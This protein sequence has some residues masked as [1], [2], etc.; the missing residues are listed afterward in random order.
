MEPYEKYM[1]NDFKPG[2]PKSSSVGN[3]NGVGVSAADYRK[4]RTRT[5]FSSNVQSKSIEVN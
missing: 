3:A 5:D 2:R 1:P 4:S